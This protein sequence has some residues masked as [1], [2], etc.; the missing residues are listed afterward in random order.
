[1]GEVVQL[2]QTGVPKKAHRFKKINPENLVTVLPVSEQIPEEIDQ[3]QIAKQVLLRR[4]SNAPRTRKELAQDLKKKKIEEDIAQNALDRFEELGLINDQTYSEN[5]VSTTHQRRKLGKKALKQ[6]LRSKGVSEEIA[7][8]AVSQISEDEEFSAALALALKKIRSIQNDDPQTQIR[9]IVGLLARKG[10][11][12][13]LSFQ[14][15]KEV[16][17]DFPEGLATIS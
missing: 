15:A 11:S 14:V 3:N 5:F 13:S 1:M 17:K 8:Q 4:L 9:K 6:Q 10:Y 7:S 12:S 2:Q 16:I